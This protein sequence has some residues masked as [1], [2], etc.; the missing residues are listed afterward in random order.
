MHVAKLIHL[1]DFNDYYQSVQLPYSDASLTSQ[2]IS[3]SSFLTLLSSGS[4]DTN[5]IFSFLVP[6]PSSYVW[7][8]LCLKSLGESQSLP[9]TMEGAK[10]RYLLSQLPYAARTWVHGLGS[11]YFKQQLVMQRSWDSA[12]SFYYYVNINKRIWTIIRNTSYLNNS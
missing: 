3:V 1:L 8:I 2:R 5:Y 10:T 9:P 12:K 7:G 4:W 6:E 11:A